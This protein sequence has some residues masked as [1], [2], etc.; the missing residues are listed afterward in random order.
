MNK[1]LIKISIF[2]LSI[3]LF[4]GNVSANE[5]DSYLNEDARSHKNGVLENRLS[6]YDLLNPS[7]ETF[8]VN[9]EIIV[10]PDETLNKLAEITSKQN[11][12]I[13]IIASATGALKNRSNL[14]T[15]LIGNNVG[16]LKFQLVQIEDQ[17]YHLNN[18]SIETSDNLEK[19]RIDI[20]VKFLKDKKVE[21]SNFI[22]EQE[23]EFSLFGWLTKIL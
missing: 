7:K 11:I 2:A 3:L 19:D 22:T 16:I 10:I 8:A 12:S 23:Q 9:P 1:K 4:S 6:V 13:K 14:K 5:I 18:L 21:I 20:Q 15:F 17:A